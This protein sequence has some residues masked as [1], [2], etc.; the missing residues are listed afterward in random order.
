MLGIYVPH[1]MN[2]KMLDALIKRALNAEE[3]I[4]YL[5]GIRG[6]F[7]VTF[8]SSPG[9]L[10]PNPLTHLTALGVQTRNIVAARIVPKRYRDIP[11]RQHRERPRAVQAHQAGHHRLPTLGCICANLHPLGDV[12]QL[13]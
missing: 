1:A 10:T 5:E 6:R 4:I 9:S 12:L 8:L 13:I 11:V 3:C 2:Y 7:R